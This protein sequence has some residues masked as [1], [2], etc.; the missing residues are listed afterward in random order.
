MVDGANFRDRVAGEIRYITRRAA[1]HGGRAV[2]IGQCRLFSTE[3]GDAWIIDREDHLALRFAC[4]G[5]LEPFHVEETET[6]LQSTG[7]ATIASK[8]PRS[9]TLIATPAQPQ[10]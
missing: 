6:P 10:P 7:R 4:Q 9:S 1:E 5:D 2:T 8:A 3:S